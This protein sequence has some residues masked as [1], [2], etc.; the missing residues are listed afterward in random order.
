MTKPI[1]RD[2]MY[3]KR[4][5]DADIIELCVAKGR[6]GNGP[7]IVEGNRSAPGVRVENRRLR[8]ELRG[9]AALVH[10]GLAL[11]LACFLVAPLG[12]Q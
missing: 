1:A 2:L 9:G 7:R 4:V 6:M 10:E 8:D 11:D 5:F 12:A 3:R